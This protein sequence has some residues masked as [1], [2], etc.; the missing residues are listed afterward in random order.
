M[1]QK[2]T[3]LKIIKHAKELIDKGIESGDNSFVIFDVDDALKRLENYELQLKK[4]FPKSSIAYSYKSNNL[5]QWCQIISNHVLYAEVCSI[6]EM[7]LA[8]N[9]GFKR[10]IFDG[11]LKMTAELLK[12]I[13]L[14]AFVEID[15]FN[16]YERIV[17]LCQ[18]YKLT[19]CVHVRLSHYYDDN[20]SRFGLSL[21]EATEL[22]DLLIHKSN[23]I[24]LGGFHL[25]VG[26]NLPNAEK[27][28][29]AIIQY[30]ELISKYMPVNGTLNLG[31]GIPADSFFSSNEISTPEPEVFFSSIHDTLK[32]CFDSACE[33]WHYIFEPGRHL[34]EDFG[35]FIGKVT[36]T[37]NRYGVDVAQTNIGINWIPSI[38]N[39]DHSFTSFHDNNSL[40]NELNEYIIAGFNCFECDC[41]FPSVIQSTDLS[42]SFFSIRGCGGYDMQTGNQWTRNLYPVYSVINGLI[43]ISR[44]HKKDHDFRKYDVS[45][46]NEPIKINDELF[47]FYP[48]LRYAEKLFQLIQDNKEHFIKTMA[49]PEFVNEISDSVSF[50]EKSKIDNQNQTAL[51]LFPVYKSNIAGVIS[52]NVIDRTNK[53]AYIGYWLGKSFQGKGIIT[54]AIKNLI[55]SYSSMGLINRF[56]I[57]CV[58]E[59]KKSNAVA[60]R[61]GFTL[62]GVL[63]KAEILN[64]V[65][66]DQ[67][68]YAKILY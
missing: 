31:S 55:Y 15:N 27:I 22:L 43:D 37:K 60:L 49:W 33:Q 57:K 35:Y 46:S 11:P 41:L 25:H 30:Q 52:F 39:W 36:S 8:R 10:I 63:R 68:I 12:A 59:N 28:C 1:A 50:I 6:D 56:V 54:N 3:P 32:I 23:Y 26:S 67:N 40:N 48:E 62:E 42:D 65:A 24:T 19:C 66:H 7:K 17:E 2:M 29:N 44:V 18:Q 13:E 51:V 45:I 14:G 61:C 38:R 53:T 64:G 4:I 58:V 47:L 16:E 34:V 21:S 9:D 20:L 5:A